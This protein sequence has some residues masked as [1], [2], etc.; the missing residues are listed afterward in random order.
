MLIKTNNG[1]ATLTKTASA[2]LAEYETAVKEIKK[3]HDAFKA[4]LMAE[5]EKHNI[6]KLETP[7]LLINYI[8]A[9][10]KESFDSKGFRMAHPELYDEYIKLSPVKPSVRIKVK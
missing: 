5:M 10:T 7:E 6:I 2:Q 4:E 8:G 3:K 1:V 9:T